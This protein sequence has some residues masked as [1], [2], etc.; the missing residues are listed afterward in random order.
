MDTL[1]SRRAKQPLLNNYLSLSADE[2]VL[3]QVI[4]ARSITSPVA[5]QVA[6]ERNVFTIGHPLDDDMA[7]GIDQPVQRSVA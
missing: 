1:I 2:L 6:V 7:D 5:Q 3:Y 4:A